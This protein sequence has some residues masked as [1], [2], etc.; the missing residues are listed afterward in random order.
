METVDAFGA[1]FDTKNNENDFNEVKKYWL[2]LYGEEELKEDE[3]IRI[4]PQIKFEDNSKIFTLNDQINSYD[5]LVKK[6]N[7]LNNQYCKD[8][9]N[10][11]GYSI[12]AGIFNYDP[13]NKDEKGNVVK[14]SSA[15][16]KRI[17]TIAID[18]DTHIPNSKERFVLGNLDDL[19]IKFTLLAAYL[20]IANALQDNHVEIPRP[21]LAGTTGGGLQLV[22]EFSRFM[23]KNEATLIFNY[24]K[25]IIAKLTFDVAIKDLLGN[26]QK[27]NLQLDP[28]F[29]DITHVQRVMGLINQKYQTT[30]R[31]FDIFVDDKNKQK[32]I[33]ENMRK[34]YL[35]FIDASE[36]TQSKKETFKGYVNNIFDRGSVVLL[37]ESVK[38]INVDA[39]LVTAKIE[40]NSN[41]SFI[42]PSE[43]KSIEMDLL[44]KLKENNI[45]SI[46]LFREHVTVDHESVSF[47]ALKCPFHEDNSYSFAIYH[48]DNFDVFYDFHD[49]KSRTLVTFWEDLFGVNKTT[50]ISQIASKAGIKLGK[51]E[52]KDFESLE[53]EEIVDHLLEKVDTENFVY[54]RLAN[55]NRQCKVRHKDTGESY[56]F[57]GPKMLANH[58]LQNQLKVPEPDRKLTEKFIEKFQQSILIDAFEEFHPGKPTVF[59]REFIKFVNLWVPS[60]NYKESHSRA[61]EIKDEFPNGLDIHE[62]IKLLRERTPWAFKYVQQM[63]QNGNIEWF[64]N[65]LVNTA[66]FNVM[67]TIPVTFG[68]PG[69]GK[70]LFVSTIL[71]WY[72]NSEY[73]KILNSDRVMSNFNSMLESASLIVLDE[74]DISG[75]RDFDALKFLT[76][77]DKIAI[78]KK[79]VDA[80]MRRRYF[81]IILFSN[82]ET[83][84]RHSFDD[85]R[86]QYFRTE[87]TLLQSVKDWGVSIEEFIS[88]VKEE[89]VEFWGILLNTN[90][91]KKHNISN[92]KDKIYLMQILKQHSFGDLILKLLNN[93]WQNIALQLNEN[94]SDPTIMKSNL[95][96]LQEIKDQFQRANKLSLTLINRY[97]SA[98]NFRYKTSIQR[99]IQHNNLQEIGIDIEV[100]SEEVLI[101]INK[102]KLKN[103]TKVPNMLDVVMFK[104][105]IKSLVKLNSDIIE[106]EKVIDGIEAEIE[107]EDK[108]DKENNDPMKIKDAQ[109]TGN[110]GG[111]ENIVM[112]GMMPPPPPG[113]AG[114]KPI[115][116]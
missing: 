1:I 54:Y 38:T 94:V 92:E 76:G 91:N 86:I 4:V 50:A 7:Q 75:S 46:D 25:K 11:V 9:I 22:F 14:P 70:N 58:V 85:R 40:K 17:K 93:E 110:T 19:Y 48:N 31:S 100:T 83:P 77:N 32:E 42:K 81:N 41:K 109:D 62:S 108:E 73:T 113:A 107:S 87:R 35:E 60:K 13:N 67:P 18:I 115:P 21:T 23:D 20:Y 80:Q 49:G 65:W 95:E 2:S 45:K 29:A 64:V 12:S 111:V 43:L 79:G 44:Y 112:P 37:N 34:E 63:T 66:K 99:F 71:E 56:D 15:T 89:M 30:A 26:I 90:T 68:T 39:N 57:D 114:V 33:L 69:I 53:I 84:V 97:L 55:K 6:I 16:F 102:S 74:G 10:R 82:G 24:L 104:R 61:N 28:T 98:L 103:L 52:R 105:S 101:T 78:E 47:T 5:K 27:V 96:M 36:Y 72:Q 59:Q 3:T 88:Y 51:S 116:I 106:A 8:G